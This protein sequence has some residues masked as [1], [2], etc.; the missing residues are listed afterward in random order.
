MQQLTALRPLATAG[1]AA[2]GAGMIALTPVLSTDV[3]SDLQRGTV[4]IQHRAIELADTVANPI[5]TWI[6]TFQAAGINI[7]SLVT[8]FQAHPFPGLEQLAAN[9]LQYGVDYVSPYHTAANAAA[10]YFLGTG[11]SDF[12]P[13]IQQA[14]AEAAAGQ[15]SGSSGAVQTL[16]GALYTNPVIQVLEPLETIP[17]I[18]NSI[19]QNLANATDYLT[20]NGIADI[21]VFFVLGLPVAF[22]QALGTSVQ[23]VYDSF[24]AGDTV[25]ALV[26]AVDIPGAV[27]NALLN[28]SYSGGNYF[29]GLISDGSGL[30]KTL[31]LTIP[32]QLAPEIVAPGAQNT[33]SGG[34]L[35]TAYQ[36][37]FNTLTNGWPT[38]QEVFNNL[39][40]VID[41]ALSKSGGAA[42]AVNA[43]NFAALA[44]AASALPG[45]SVGVVKGFDPAAVTNIAASLGPSL[46]AEVAGSLGANLA[47][48][49]A[50]T[51]SVDLSRVALHILSAL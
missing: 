5:Q 10:N 49:L 9:F 17:Q 31:F 6:D 43:G 13:L 4:A 38:A 21:G 15:F 35:L 42:A 18:L 25:G 19:T 8:Q 2:I 14:L 3:A 32:Q 24:T 34:S 11:S 12:V 51:L 41:Y 27:T 46:A 33:M 39:L 26:N 22:E 1:A 48:S 20:T 23:N 44:P 40:N 29:N 50:T 37:F 47:G 28:G 36:D 30:A 16:V 7:Q 45:L